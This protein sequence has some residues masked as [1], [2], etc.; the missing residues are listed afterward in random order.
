MGREHKLKLTRPEFLRKILTEGD[1]HRDIREADLIQ[2]M[3][4][5]NALP[6][7]SY[8]AI[9][10]LDMDPADM[11]YIG[12]DEEGTVAMKLS[13]KELARRVKQQKHKEIISMGIH[14]YRMHVKTSGAYVFVT[15]E[16]LEDEI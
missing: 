7:C 8:T 2:L 15:V 1:D 12:I 16:E 11:I 5:G 4:Q 9:M 6:Y 13:S 3:N 14:R 10:E